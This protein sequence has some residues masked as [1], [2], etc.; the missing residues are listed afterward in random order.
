MGNT[1]SGNGITLAFAIDNTGSMGDD[2]SA[3]RIA[4]GKI[5]DHVKDRKQHPIVNFVATTFNDPDPP[6][7]YKTT[8]REEFQ[9]KLDSIRVYGGDDCPE[10]AMS[11][12]K[13]AIEESLNNSIVYVFTDASAK[14]TASL[15][16][17]VVQLAKQK[18]VQ[19]TFLLTGECSGRHDEKFLIY[20]R[21]ANETLG[22]VYHIA[23]KTQVG[24]VLQFIAE[25]L[26]EKTKIIGS[27]KTKIEDKNT[28][29]GR[30]EK[31]MYVD[32]DHTMKS[33][34]VILNGNNP[35][36]I[37]KNSKN[38]IVDDFQVET[39]VNL[40]EILIKQVNNPEPEV[41]S[42]LALRPI[43]EDTANPW[44]PNTVQFLD[45]SGNKIGK[46]MK[47]LRVPHSQNLFRSP[48]FLVPD[49]LFYIEV[50]G[51]DA[52][53]NVVKR[54]S[55]SA[56]EPQKPNDKEIS[57]NGGW[58]EWSDWTKCS[59][60]CGSGVRFRYR[61][62][63][64]PRPLN[65]GNYC[66]GS[67]VNRD[68]CNEHPC[69]RNGGWSEWKNW[70]KC[71]ASCG[72]GLK[73]GFRTC[74]NPTPLYGG[75]P[76]TGDNFTIE[77]C[78]S[79]FCYPGKIILRIAGLVN[80]KRIT[81]HIVRVDLIADDLRGNRTKF[82]IVTEDIL[83]SPYMWS[84]IY[85]HITSSVALL[86]SKEM[87]NSTNGFALSRG[88]FHQISKINFHSG[89]LLKIRHYGHGVDSKDTLIIDVQLNGD[90]PVHARKTNIPISPNEKILMHT[91]PGK[92]YIKQ[93]LNATDEK[94]KINIGYDLVEIFEY[95]DK[96]KFMS[97]VR[98]NLKLS[99]FNTQL[100]PDSRILTF[101]MDSSMGPATTQTC[102]S[103]YILEE[104]KYCSDV[105]EC[106][107]RTHK[108]SHDCKNLLG[109]YQC[110]CPEDMELDEDT[111]TC[112]K[113]D[114]P[115]SL[116]LLDYSDSEY[117]YELPDKKDA[118]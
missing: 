52:S 19:V 110:T 5:M 30:Y 10:L 65:G 60:A 43:T 41:N 76:C 21:L 54:I 87:E 90:V 34:T 27:G 13:A 3:V 111:Y 23:D 1:H 51:Y 83:R 105:D 69:P 101:S 78:E 45:M 12:I 16:E 36:M 50:T 74:T 109:S 99:E 59:V 29:T 96:S 32:V 68:R 64:N 102:P 72:K 17:H 6:V 112:K 89:E 56:I 85:H 67:L 15:G 49:Q 22:Q 18:S 75:K 57:R 53:G 94:K 106:V 39:K 97:F 107:M 92:I 79:K 61:E 108:C 44:N 77:E 38:I 40:A 25:S 81:E 84:P 118:K 31:E 117:D 70:T 46:V 95:S 33:F 42:F 98:Q 116:E 82:R 80:G 8:D 73:T 48:R 37:I 100:T 14:D 66:E 71:S 103:G 62:C 88:N 20:E 9:K 35:K 24:Q 4:L 93:S 26:N 63:N 7:I 114:I 47:L 55:K 91:E 58:S 28:D 113:I 11:G 2:I 115:E 86:F 104:R